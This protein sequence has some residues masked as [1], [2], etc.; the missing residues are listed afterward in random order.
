MSSFLEL[1]KNA[2]LAV[3]NRE[4]EGMIIP[5]VL[6]FCRNTQA[7][8]VVSSLHVCRDLGKENRSLREN[9]M[10]KE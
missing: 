7:L 4:I 9:E 5:S 10:A 1:K 6:E 2:L 3:S 8:R